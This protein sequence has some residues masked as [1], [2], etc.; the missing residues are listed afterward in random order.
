[1]DA[2]APLPYQELFLLSPVAA[3]VTRVSDGLVIDVNAAWE[4]L[5]GIAR[6]DAIGRTT[7]ELPGA[8]HAGA[9]GGALQGG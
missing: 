7:V 2:D 4:A 6:R 1:M 5:S 8:G 3:C 9:H